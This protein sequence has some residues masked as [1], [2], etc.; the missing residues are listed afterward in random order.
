MFSIP[1]IL[2]AIGFLPMVIFS[3]YWLA[4]PYEHCIRDVV[5]NEVKY[6]SEFEGDFSLLR[7]H[8][9]KTARW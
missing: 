8:C 4:S 5:R 3:V 6:E 7:T 1:K 9:E 2:I